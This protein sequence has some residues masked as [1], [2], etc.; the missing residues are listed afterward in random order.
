MA[1][2]HFQVNDRFHE[3]YAMKG[4]SVVTG[5]HPKVQEYSKKQ[6]WEVETSDDWADV[7]IFDHKTAEWLYTHASCTVLC[8]TKVDA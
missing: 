3:F 1:R 6:I 7:K 5:W 2:N 8:R 4:T